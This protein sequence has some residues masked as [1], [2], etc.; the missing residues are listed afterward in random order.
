MRERQPIATL[1]PPLVREQRVPKP[2]AALVGVLDGVDDTMEHRPIPMLASFLAFVP[3]YPYT[4]PSV[5]GQALGLLKAPQQM[6]LGA[7]E[8]A[9]RAWPSV[10][11]V[12]ATGVFAAVPVIRSPLAVTQDLGM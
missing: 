12:R 3:T 11:T 9:S 5:P 6:P 2:N 1:P 4:V 7:V 10:P 8:Q